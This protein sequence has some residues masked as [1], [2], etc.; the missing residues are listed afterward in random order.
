MLVSKLHAVSE[1]GCSSLTYTG[2]GIEVIVTAGNWTVLVDRDVIV[3]QAYQQAVRE[4]A[5][6][7]SLHREGDRS[8]R[9]G[10]QLHS[11]DRER[12]G[13]DCTAGLSAGCAS[14]QREGIAAELTQEAVL[15]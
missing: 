7:L 1:G 8:D 10:W 15:K 2:S 9:H 3:L 14:S 12:R 13:R 11:A 4:R 6:H 5:S